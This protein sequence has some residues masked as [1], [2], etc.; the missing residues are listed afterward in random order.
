MSDQRTAVRRDA[1][2]ILTILLVVLLRKV[3]DGIFDL[4]RI[5][6]KAMFLANGFDEL[7]GLWA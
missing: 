3:F 4:R 7:D 2:R 6:R 5:V 1:N